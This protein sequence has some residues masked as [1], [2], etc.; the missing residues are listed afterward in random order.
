MRLPGKVLRSLCGKTVL[1]H[2]IERVGMADRVNRI[3]VA[4]TNQPIDNAIEDQARQCGAAIYRGSENDVLDRYY[5]AA[6]CNKAD[7]IVRITSDCPLLDPALLNTMI[8]R[9]ILAQ[10]DP[11]PVDYL[12]NTM[13][14][15]F[16]RGFD[17]EI[18]RSDALAKAWRDATAPEERE[19][20]TPFFYRHPEKFRLVNHVSSSDRS[21]Y[22]VTL[23]TEADWQ[24]IERVMME[25]GIGARLISGQELLN[26]LDRHPEIVAINADVEQISLAKIQ[27][28][29]QPLQSG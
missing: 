14:R 16:P 10:S 11:R 18:F 3:V 1:Q 9:F 26:F 7:A 22:R 17:V 2:V 6:T 21:R 5:Q 19:H 29:D 28:T 13:T 27:R 20:V 8:C 24:M 15:T 25:I 4:T 12:S 23:D